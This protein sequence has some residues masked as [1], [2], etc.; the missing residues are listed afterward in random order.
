MNPETCLNAL[1]A[2]TLQNGTCVVCGLVAAERQQQCAREAIAY[3]ARQES[4]GE[5]YRSCRMMIQDDGSV[6][7]G[8][9]GVQCW[10]IPGHQC[11]CM[12]EREA[13]SLVRSHK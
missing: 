2:G 3:H 6:T 9:G 8:P 5:D 13:R 1:C 11:D 4:A 10:L 7:D 12:T